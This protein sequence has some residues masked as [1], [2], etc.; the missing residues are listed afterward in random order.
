M[1][2]PRASLARPAP[3]FVGDHLALDFLN[4]TGTPWGKPIEWL[5]EAADLVDWLERAHAVPPDIAARF[6]S[7]KDD[8]RALDAVARQA[9]DLREWWRGFVARHQGKPL[10]ARA[11]AELEPLNRLLARDD[12]YHVVEVADHEARKDAGARARAFRRRQGRRWTTPERLLQPVAEAI[13][14]LVCEGDFALVRSCEGA[15]CTFVFYDRS[16][17]HARRWCS[18]ALCGN[19]AKAAAY[20][21]Q[22]RERQGKTR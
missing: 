4:S 22:L 14:D 3:F 2:A 15:G 7:G 16:K 10:T 18:M 13:S 20:R 12:V 11:M 19:R 8:V 5:G 17:A 9:R 1:T 6:R 21:T